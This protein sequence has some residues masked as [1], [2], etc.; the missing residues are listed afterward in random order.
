MLIRGGGR[1]AAGGVYLG[2]GATHIVC[3]PDSAFR[4]LAM[5]MCSSVQANPTMP[6]ACAQTR[7]QVMMLESIY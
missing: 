1:V 7:A 6:A 5:G 3:Q 2:G 4:W